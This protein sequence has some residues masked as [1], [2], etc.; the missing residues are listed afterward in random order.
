VI[1][2]KGG[3]RATEKVCCGDTVL[4]FSYCFFVNFFAT[5]LQ[6]NSSLGVSFIVNAEPDLTM[7][8]TSQ[9][10]SRVKWKPSFQLT[11]NTQTT[12]QT[13]M[14]YKKEEKWAR[15]VRNIANLDHDTALSN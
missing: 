15:V 2:H 8:G 11:K 1:L 7:H 13:S 3:Q 10:F 5:L 6:F 9:N 12:G 14:I 4:G